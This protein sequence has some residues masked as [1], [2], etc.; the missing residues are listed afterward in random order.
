MLQDRLQSEG[1][2]EMRFTGLVL[3]I[4]GLVA[5]ITGSLGYNRQTTSLEVGGLKTTATEHRA[6]PA[7]PLVGAMILIGGAALL[8]V[9]GR[10]AT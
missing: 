10:R 4:I 3:V 6:S 9:P 1:T 8:V 5:L 2:A 7:A